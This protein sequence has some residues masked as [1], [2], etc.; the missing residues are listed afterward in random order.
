MRIIM[1]Q[2]P[3]ECLDQI[4]VVDASTDGTANYA[5]SIGCDVVRQSRPGLHAAYAEAFP[6]VRGEFVLTFSP[7]GNSPPE[8]IP[9]LIEKISEGHD[10]V[11]ASRYLPPAQS[12]DDDGL[13]AFGNHLF[14]HAINLLHGESWSRPYTDAM[15]IYRIYR[16]RLYYELALDAPDAYA[17]EK[18]FRTFLGVEPLL[19][20]RAA[21]ANCRIA[22][23][24]VDEPPRLH[25]RRKLQ[26][27][28]W[29][30]AYMAQILRETLRK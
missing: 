20:V 7:D 8:A 24:P 18:F 29:G 6:H 27:F 3:R 4:L 14:T 25:G 13:T 12:E 2:V 22:E 1:P 16:T 23:I 21:H 9:R 19:S 26:I 10:M 5:R 17:P 11:I 28:R 15:V 30:A